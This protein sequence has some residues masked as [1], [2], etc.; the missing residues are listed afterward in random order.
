MRFA[1]EGDVK[2]LQLL[3]ASGKASPF[4]VDKYDNNPLHVGHL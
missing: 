4:D 1:R 3:F 2:N